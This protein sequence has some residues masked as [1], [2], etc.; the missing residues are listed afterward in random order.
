MYCILWQKTL[1]FMPFYFLKTISLICLPS[2]LTHSFSL[3]MRFPITFRIRSGW[4]ARISSDILCLNSFTFLVIV[5]Q[6]L[7]LRKPHKPS[8]MACLLA[9]LSGLRISAHHTA[10][11]FSGVR[12]FRTDPCAEAVSGKFL[13][14]N[15][16]VLGLGTAP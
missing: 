2:V 13:I 4:I 9:D 7:A 14:Y 15:F 16:I 11:L 8:A 3:I 10:S 12:A 6:T 5:T 1:H